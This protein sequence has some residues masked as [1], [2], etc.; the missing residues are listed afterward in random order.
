MRAA[1]GAFT[2]LYVL[3][4]LYA[5]VSPGLWALNQGVAV[6]GCVLAVSEG[7]RCGFPGG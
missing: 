3:V 6:G 2:V 7:A 5:L 1:L 4:L